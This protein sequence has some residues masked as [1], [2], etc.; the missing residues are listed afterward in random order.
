MQ[1]SVPPKLSQNSFF[2][3]IILHILLLCFLLS[4]STVMTFRPKEVQKPPQLY[5]P[6]YVYR[7]AITPPPVIRTQT[8]PSV[9]QPDTSENNATQIQKA[10]NKTGTLPSGTQAK[11]ESRTKNPLFQKN[12]LA[13]S[14][15]LIQQ[16]QVDS[17]L[18]N[19][20]NSEPPILL[21]GDKQSIVDPLIKL[22][23]RSLSA[24]FH[25]PKIEGNFGVRGRVYVGLV[26]HPE[27]YFSD[28]EIVE[29]SEIQDFNAAALYAVNT[30]PRVV[31]ADKFLS[32]PKRFVVGF[33]FDY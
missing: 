33:I 25:Y 12:I 18:N 22:L 19:M 32:G 5:L 29:A 27:G 31:G 1:L 14:Q 11:S 24:N 3:S 23:G 2:L 30:A 26:L 13:M 6:S 28:V 8:K 4:I 15:H 7:G 9:T 17:A 20:N 10:Q 21:I 16:N